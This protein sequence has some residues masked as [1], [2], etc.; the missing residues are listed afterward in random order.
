MK[1]V[2]MSSILII[3]L[4]ITQAFPQENDIKDAYLDITD[5][6]DSALLTQKGVVELSGIMSYNDMTTEFDNGRYEFREVVQTLQIESGISY[7]II[8]DLSIGF[9]FSYFRQKIGGTITEQTMTGPILKK[10]FGEDRLRPF[11]FANYL[12]LVGDNS[13]GGE[14]DCGAGVLYHIS[15]NL[16]ISTLLKYGQIFSDHD[17]IKK[18][19]RIFFGI[20]LT[21]FIL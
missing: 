5:A 7:F 13:D 10:Y 17:Y 6:I 3:I 20:G 1:Q 21:N 16:G 11:V 18:Q 12:F 4:Y 19:N 9:L 2:F 14:L 8:N 15:G